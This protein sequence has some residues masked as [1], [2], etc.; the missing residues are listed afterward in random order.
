M[1]C[2]TIKK[3]DR[4][5]VCSL[6]QYDFQHCKSAVI[7]HYP[8]DRFAKGH[9]IHE[10]CS[11]KLLK[12]SFACPTCKKSLTPMRLSLIQKDDEI[13]A[14]GAISPI[15]TSP[16]LSPLFTTAAAIS[17]LFSASFACSSIFIQN[18]PAHWT[19]IGMVGFFTLYTLSDVST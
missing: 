5:E 16:R 19:A 12:T 11:K 14:E 3:I 13:C 18:L 15:K 8:I 10:L 17:A 4:D 7:L 6:C 9:P 1:T 2:L